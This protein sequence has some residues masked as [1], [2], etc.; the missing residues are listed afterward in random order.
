ME[1]LQFVLELRPEAAELLGM[2]AASGGKELHL[3]SKDATA[4][5]RQKLRALFHVTGG[6]GNW[7][8]LSSYLL[9]SIRA[10][11]DVRQ[12]LFELLCRTI[13]SAADPSEVRF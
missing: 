2:D 3:R 13:E 5:K 4:L 11:T 7:R 1:L 10:Q 6:G 9:E 12:E 8:D